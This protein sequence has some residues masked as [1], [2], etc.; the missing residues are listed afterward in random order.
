MT[1]VDRFGGR[2]FSS[3][4][5]PAPWTFLRTLALLVSMVGVSAPAIAGQ[6]NLAWD[7]VANATGYKIHFGQTSGSYTSSV[8]AGNTLTQPVGGLNEGARYY[9]TV[10]AYGP[11]GMTESGYSNQVSA[12]VPT[13]STPP[14]PSAP[15]VASFTASPTSGT[16]PL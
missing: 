8:D 1:L 7:A 5:I 10:T 16:A 9:F 4:R 14:P 13:T 11:Q 3:C 6:L 12:I 15:P 2:V